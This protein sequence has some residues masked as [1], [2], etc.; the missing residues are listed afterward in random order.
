M[1]PTLALRSRQRSQ[2]WNIRALPAPGVPDAR[3]PLARLDELDVGL[4]PG[5]APGITG[6]GTAV[7]YGGT[8]PSSPM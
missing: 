4:F 5:G 8:A 7:W 2:A 6:G 3:I 1:E